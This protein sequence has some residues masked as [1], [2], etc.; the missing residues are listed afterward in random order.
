[1]VEQFSEIISELR[2]SRGLSQRKAAGDLEISQ[3]LLSHYENG[4][5]EPK[6][7][8]VIKICEYYGVSADY[9]L[10]RTAV[11]ENPAVS[12]ASC[13]NENGERRSI[14]EKRKTA[15]LFEGLQNVF[16][17]MYESGE[18]DAADYIR[19][20]IELLTYKLLRHMYSL[21]DGGSMPQRSFEALCDSELKLIEARLAEVSGDGR[22]AD[23][24]R[25]EVLSWA[26]NI[27][28]ENNFRKGE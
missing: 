12:R 23:F 28:R 20:S 9:L 19:R 8:F 17:E 2:K 27:D 24:V 7:E 16:S 26:R 18:N 3:A 4:L 15:E 1:M 13:Y 6:F 11:P 22:N 21:G 10:G 25:A 5:R 14:W